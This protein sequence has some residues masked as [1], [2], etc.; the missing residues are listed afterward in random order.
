MNTYRKI[1]LWPVLLAGLNVALC[2]RADT[3]DSLFQAVRTSK[4]L[5]CEQVNRLFVALDAESVTDSLVVVDRQMKH[6]DVMLQVCYNMGLL[7]NNTYRH[8]QAADAFCEAARY[9]R[10]GDDSRHEAEA[11]SAA[12]VQ[13][14]MLGDFEK[15]VALCIDALHIDSLLNDTASLS[16]D[17]NILSGSSL[18]AGHVEDAVR[19][20]EKSI[21][22]EKLLHNPTKLAI[23]YGSAAEIL[24]KKGDTAGALR[25]A[26][27]AYELDR[28]AGNAIGLARRLS[29]MADIY[30]AQKEYE[31]A[32]RYYRRAIDTL[33][34]H[35]ELHSLAI[36]Y[37]LLANLLQLEN[38]HAEALP[39][40]EKAQ[41]IARQ[42]G[43][44]FFLSLTSRSMADSQTALGRDADAAR[45]LREALLLS[46]SLHSEKQQ[47][48][49]ADFRAR[50]DVQE[51]KAGAERQNGL[52]RLQQWSILGL[53]LLLALA[54]VLF[55]KSRRKAR[56]Q[57]ENIDTPPAEKSASRADR[58]FLISVSDIVHAN[59]KSRKITIDLLAEELCMSRSQFVRR[60]SAIAGET[61]NNYIIRIKMEKAVRLLRDTTMPVK[62]VA[63]ECGFDES[64]YFIHVFKQMYGA[65]P[66]QFRQTPG[67]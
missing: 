30:V 26:T 57:E 15:A 48:M 29:Q 35:R 66:Q 56:R 38:R 52:L 11:L 14:H 23:R 50:F 10:Q 9:A 2:L 63:Y 36:D 43:N 33:E 6:D 46:D 51:A 12:A 27:M 19:Y 17:L 1:L 64:N 54:L 8:V 31:A 47:Q 16:C 28:K 34:V 41:A 4:R 5:D 21:Q 18:S 39:Y 24:N 62:E 20:I 3:L 22:W 59:M 49:L 65:T 32:E 44:R 55:L 25:Y 7:Y 61:P 53:A 45:N 37:R 60:L 40:Y 42:T 13:Y 58:Q 67:L